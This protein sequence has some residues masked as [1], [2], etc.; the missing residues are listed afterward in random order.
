MSLVNPRIVLDTAGYPYDGWAFAILGD[1]LPDSS[2]YARREQGNNPLF[3][4]DVTNAPFVEGVEYAL[5]MQHPDYCPDERL[6]RYT[7][8]IGGGAVSIPENS[9]GENPAL[10]NG[11]VLLP[12]LFELISKATDAERTSALLLLLQALNANPSAKAIFCEYVSSC[13][14]VSDV[15]THRFANFIHFEFVPEAVVVTDPKIARVDVNDCDRLAGWSFGSGQMVRITRDGVTVASIPTTIARPDVVTY[16]AGQGITAPTDVLGY[17]YT[18]TT[19]ESNGTHV[20][21]VY[22]G[23]S[24]VEATTDVG[25]P[26]SVT[27]GTTP[28]EEEEPPPT[29]PLILAYPITDHP[30]TAYGTTTKALG[31]GQFTGGTTPYTY[32]A[33]FFS[34][35][36]NAWTGLPSWMTLNTSTGALTVAVPDGSIP[37][38]DY[39]V[40]I[41]ATDSAGSGA[42]GEYK[43]KVNV[44]VAPTSTYR[45][46]DAAHSSPLTI[47]EGGSLQLR[48]EQQFSNGTWAVYTGSLTWL[49]ISS[50][51]DHINISPTG[52]LTVNAGSISANTD[53]M[54]NATFSNLTVIEATVT[55]I[56][57]PTD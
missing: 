13:V 22:V 32:S 54:V 14:F 35:G 24:S 18:K 6:V 31:S 43:V 50:I 8:P 4:A 42:A 39:E 27:C 56:N 46:T 10:S 30:V 57:L 53:V 5:T 12:G 23:S 45:I 2:D 51:S 48:V 41:A 44:A 3:T 29:P 17:V 19:E 47:I 21:R 20:W 16:L 9:P 15:I 25:A 34:T 36:F 49:T 52:L 1:L 26:T 7:F 28:P 40:R 55:V 37:N 33:L 11:G 38:R